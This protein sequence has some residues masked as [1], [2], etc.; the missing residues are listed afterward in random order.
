MEQPIKTLK[1]LNR[2]PF[3]LAVFMRLL[4]LI[5][6]FGM[7]ILMIA[8]GFPGIR[9]GDVIELPT[10]LLG[11]A[12]FALSVSLLVKIFILER[13][14][15]S[16]LQYLFYPDRLV[17]YNKKRGRILHEVFFE[18]MPEFTFHE[19][20]KNFGYIVIGKNEPIM[21]RGGIFGQNIGVNMKDPDIML[22]NLPE[23]KKEY[24]FLKELV[25]AHQTSQND[26]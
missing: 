13:L 3:T 14:R 21:A 11:I 9:K 1:P 16:Q 26:G 24:L 6:I 25:E 7:S 19:N 10:F 23:V 8:T 15:I 20:L 12:F 2:M 5:P 18:Q 22:E 4:V 17:I